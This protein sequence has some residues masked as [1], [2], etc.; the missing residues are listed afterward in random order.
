MVFEKIGFN[1]TESLNISLRNITIETDPNV[2]VNNMPS[3]VNTITENYL[4]LA[5]MIVL[6]LFLYFALSDKT[7]NGDF[8]YDDSRAISISLG[9]AASMGLL[10]LTVGLISHVE[11]V[12]LFVVLFVITQVFIIFI[13]GKN[14]P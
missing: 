7:K 4:G 11:H 12:G 6:T 2:L 3:V 9:I 10:M 14:D 5:I 1:I 8:N 13:E